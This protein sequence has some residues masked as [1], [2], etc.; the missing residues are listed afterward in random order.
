[1]DTRITIP[2]CPV[3]NT[4]RVVRTS[5]TAKN[6]ERDFITCPRRCEGSF[7]WVDSLPK[8]DFVRPMVKTD[9]ERQARLDERMK[10]FNAKLEAPASVGVFS[11]SSEPN[12]KS[13]NDVRENIPI[14]AG[15]V[16]PQVT[17]VSEESELTQAQH[18]LL[19]ER[20]GLP[21]TTTPAPLSFLKIP[22]PTL[23][24]KKEFV[25]SKYQE[26][27][28]GFVKG[29]NGNAIVQAVAGSG[30]TVTL[31]KSLEF[32]PPSADVAF[33]AFNKHIVKELEE[34]APSHVH[35]STLHSLGLKNA[36]NHLADG[37]YKKLNVNEYKL[38]D[39]W[40]D[41][42]DP[43]QRSIELKPN[44]IKLVNLL[45]ATLKEPN[46]ETIDS[47]VDHYGIEV[48]GDAEKI[49]PLTTELYQ[50][51]VAD[52]SQID[53][54][55]MIHWA[56]IGDIPCH[57]FDFLFIDEAQDFSDAQLQMALR[58]IKPNGRAI[59]VGDSKQAIYSWAGAGIDS[60][61]QAQ[62]FLNAT[63]LPLSICYRCHK[64]AIRLAQQ[65]VPH[66][67]WRE[68][69]PEGI[70]DTL[71]E[72][73][74]T[75]QAGDM[76]L[77]RTNAPLV[78]PCFTL[79]RKGIKATIRGRD[80]GNG[81]VAM[82][83]RAEKK[84]GKQVNDVLNYLQR[85]VQQEC[86]KLIRMRKEVRA[87]SLQD[88]LETIF[89]L[90]EDCQ[91]TGDIKRKI[92]QVFSDEKQAVTFSSV[93]RAKGL[94]SERVFILRPDLLPFPKAEQDWEIQCERNVKYVALTRPKQALYFVEGKS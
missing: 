75:I 80:I 53:Y 66:I 44:A 89:V 15:V 79:I 31:V 45:K 5:H 43:Y 90:S 11:S 71:S 26:A 93:H 73:P 35:V 41:L 10:D 51:S 87:A 65:L 77:C 34:R 17:G 20:A 13:A 69:A 64:G 76:V 3:C 42:I 85:Y 72:L 30:K 22:A 18:D 62:K 28:F 21:A 86:A 40:D 9:V 46:Q 84:V 37:D 4:P 2:P 91:A 23:V 55:D 1:M 83:T 33:V 19:K 38:Y 12:E 7:R 82:L 6:P 47:I 39:I 24:V 52:K 25:P 74:D 16:Q 78:S 88:Q 59:G 70:V 29:D 67:E 8:Y 63:S 81:L 48:N 58:S 57:Q 27:I 36:V 50:R 94:E 68:D 14:G 60:M 92:Q 56:A 32:T 54:T 49:Y 61:E